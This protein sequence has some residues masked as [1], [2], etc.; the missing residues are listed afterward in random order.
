MDVRLE[1]RV[2]AVGEDLGAA[3]AGGDV[4]IGGAALGGQLKPVLLRLERDP[5]RDV[6]VD[7]LLG[8]V[9]HRHVAE[10]QLGALAAQQV[11]P[12]VGPFVHDVHFCDDAEGAHALRVN[13]L[14]ELDSLRVGN[15]RVARGHSQNNTR[16]VL[17][18]LLRHGEKD[19]LDVPGLIVYGD[20]GDARQV[21]Q[22]HGEHVGRKDLEDDGL[23]RHCSLAACQA[24]RLRLDLLSDVNIAGVSL[25]R[26]VKELG[27]FSA[28]T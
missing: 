10:L 19:L 27:P 9:H 22:G 4:G 24:H 17:D 12:Y 14:R 5:H 11:L 13:L 20:L 25:A 2:D 16:L 7:V 15:V 26:F 1:E 3:A 6:H 28:G 8:A 18:V 23:R 21:D